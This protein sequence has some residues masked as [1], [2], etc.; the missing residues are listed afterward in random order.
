MGAVT[1][2]SAEP[3][4]LTPFDAAL[5][6]ELAEQAAAA[7]AH[8]REYVDEQEGRREMEVLYAELAER[9]AALERAQQQLVQTEKLAAIGQL[10]HGIAH[11]LNTPLGGVI[12]SNLSVLGQYGDALAAVAGAAHQALKQ[13][14]VGDF[15]DEIAEPLETTLRAVDLG[16]V[17]DDL[18]QLLA[19]LVA[20]ADRIAAIVRSVGTFAQRDADRVAPVNVAEALEA[21]LTVAWSELKHRGDV[22]R[23]IVDVPL[24]LGHGSELTQ[25]FVH[26]LLN[27]A[28]ALDERPGTIRI[29]TACDEQGVLVTIHDTGRGIPAEH[30][31]RVFDPFFTTRAPGHG[32]GMGLAVCHGI[33]TRHGGTVDLASTPGRGT[34]VSVRL[35]Y[36]TS[37]EVV[38]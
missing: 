19:E 24:V 21:A 2:G 15:A 6:I 35:P 26:L 8:A 14:R 18:P 27:A 32:T 11:E 7:V 10:A 9:T 30:L 20:S 25:V 4:A 34:T 37:G 12:V 29:G 5:I 31:A 17:L 38:A 13:L 36:M 22:V 23:A 16:Y 28:Q 3:A 33:I 1:V